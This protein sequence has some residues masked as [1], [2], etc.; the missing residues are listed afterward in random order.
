MLSVSQITA[1]ILRVEGGFSDHPNDPGG[2]T[3]YGVTLKTLQGLGL[4]LDGNGTVDI[5]DLRRLTPEGAAEIFTQHYYFRARIDQLPPH[6]R[7]SVYDMNVNAGARSVRLLQELLNRLG[8][9]LS[10]DGQI[11]P[12]TRAAADTAETKHGTLLRDA[13]SIARRNYYYAL[14]DSA[15]N[16]RVFARAQDGTKGGWIT[17][18]EHFMADRFHLSAAEHKQRVAQW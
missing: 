18:A 2:P 3:N 8:F 13:Y 12:K 6:L 15:P 17:R 10:V 11:G 5:D 14:G 1:Q 4:D 16:L 7:A 9:G